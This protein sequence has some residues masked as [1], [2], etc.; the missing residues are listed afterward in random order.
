MALAASAHQLFAG[1]PAGLRQ[2]LLDAFEEIVT[3][4]AKGHW[5]PAELNGGKL[6]EVTYSIIRGY[7]DDD[8]PEH[9]SKPTD[10]VAA[11]RNL[12]GADQQK[13]PR[14]LR[15]S[16]PRLLM[17]LYEVR[18]NRNVG[19]VGGEV[20]PSH[21]DATM[22]LQNAKWIMAE[23]VRVFH[24]L[25]VE[26]ASQVVEALVERDI[27]LVWQVGDAVRILDANLSMKAKTLLILL[28]SPGPVSDRDLGSYVEHSNPSVYRR[29][30]LGTAHKERLLEYDRAKGLVHI[31]PLGT[32]RAEALLAERASIGQ[33]VRSR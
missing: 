28:A 19:H 14:S 27:P 29:D 11:C 8:L 12:E 17:A 6:C 5:E 26:R 2:E 16:V 25:P 30:V 33:L 18:N 24:D 4:Y 32:Q 7:A 1:L 10:M 23:L 31:S 22:V 9:A 3:N 13:V 20:D 21:M 15:I